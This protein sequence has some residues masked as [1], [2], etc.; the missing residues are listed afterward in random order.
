MTDKILVCYC[1][2]F[3]KSKKEE[4]GGGSFA[5]TKNDKTIFV[6]KHYVTDSKVK[7]IKYLLKK[8]PFT[9]NFAEYYAMF[10]LLCY[11]IATNRNKQKVIIYSDSQLIVEQLT[12]NWDEPEKEWLATM[13]ELCMKKLQEFIDVKIL[14]V[15]RTLIVEKLGH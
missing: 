9:S 13:Y 1:D 6:K 4:N 12:G 8:Y 14:W 15:S 7:T 2:G 11:L 3:I 5:L 10:F